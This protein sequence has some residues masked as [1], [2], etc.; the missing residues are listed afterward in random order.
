LTETLDAR[1]LT[2]QP[3]AWLCLNVQPRSV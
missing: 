1:R 3:L 2:M